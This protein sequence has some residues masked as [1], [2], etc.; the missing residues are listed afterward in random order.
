MVNKLTFLTGMAVGYVLGAR[1]GRER[2]ETIK[3]AARTVSGNPAVQRAA[4]TLGH[5]ASELAHSATRVVGDRV[6]ER[7]PFAAQRGRHD[8]GAPNGRQSP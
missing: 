3:R 2:Y 5:G 7:L 1:A 6:G 4:G 8:Y